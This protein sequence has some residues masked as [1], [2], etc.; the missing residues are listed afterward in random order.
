M[1]LLDIFKRQ[2]KSK[3]ETEQSVTRTDFKTQLDIVEKDIYAKLKPVGFKKNGRTFNRRLDDG[4][5]QV[6]N[7][8]S[9][10]Y[11]IGQGYEI[12]GLRENLYGK[13]V[14]NLGV[15]IESL[16]KFQSPTENKKYYKEYDC[17]I[18]D[19]LGTLLTGQDYWW[20]ITDDNNKITQEIIEGIETIAFK[21]F[22]G[23]ETKEKI[24]SNN[25]HLPYDATPRAKLD[26]ALIVWFDDKAKGSKLFKDYY[27]SIQPAKSAHKEYVRD[28]AKELK[29]EL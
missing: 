12:P 11:P 5:I 26:I 23:L 17:Q 3:S 27:H 25:G 2:D 20:T 8:Q 15:C 21:W 19:R 28:L 10:Q 29:I 16:Y 14:V 6:I 7:L 22:S 18:R 4:I 1:G 9:G 13:F 24:I